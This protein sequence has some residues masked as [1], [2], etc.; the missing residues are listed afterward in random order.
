MKKK[1]IGIW[2]K[3][4]Y[5]K[6]IIN[7]CSYLDLFTYLYRVYPSVFIISTNSF[8]NI[9]TKSDFLKRKW[10]FNL[11]QTMEAQLKRKPT[12]PSSSSEAVKFQLETL[13]YMSKR[14]PTEANQAVQFWLEI[15]RCSHV[16]SMKSNAQMKRKPKE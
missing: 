16:V 2:P 13:L 11:H 14:E 7:L 10:Y 3:Y 6:K 8:L 5:E 12:K 9:S 1:L 15:C 4:L